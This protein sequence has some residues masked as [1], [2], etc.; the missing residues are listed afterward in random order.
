V[1]F[2]FLFVPIRVVGNSMEPTYRNGR[3]NLVNRLAYHSHAPQRGD[4]V[5]LQLD[6]HRL[7][8]LKRVVGLPG[9]RIALRDGR[10]LV[11]GQP[12]NEPYAKGSELPPTQGE[13]L[14]RDDEYFVIGDN[15]DISAYGSIHQHEV[16]GKV[17]F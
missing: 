3:I 17:V 1:L 6:R 11:N 10:V 4:V 7:V 13:I 8:L 14:L 9:E 2:K 16:I 5:A 12:L 15:R